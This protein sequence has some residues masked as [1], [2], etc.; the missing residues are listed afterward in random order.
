MDAAAE[1]EFWLQ[2]RRGLLTQLEAV[3]KT[4]LPDKYED[5]QLARRLL[6]AERSKPGKISTV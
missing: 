5:T 3:E 4:H 1:R 6:E 2:I